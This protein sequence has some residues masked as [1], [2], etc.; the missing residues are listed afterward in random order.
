MIDFKIKRNGKGIRQW[1]P[2][3]ALLF[4]FVIEIL[5]KW[6]KNNNDIKWLSFE[7]AH[8]A[9]DSLYFFQ[10]ADNCAGMLKDKNSLKIV[11]EAIK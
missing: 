6:M 9:K 5:A 4:I 7:K 1:C 11:L 8:L 2:T 10:H 3:S